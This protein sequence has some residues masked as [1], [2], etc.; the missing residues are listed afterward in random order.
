MENENDTMWFPLVSIELEQND[1]FIL[2]NTF[3]Y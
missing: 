1:E 3:R 2:D